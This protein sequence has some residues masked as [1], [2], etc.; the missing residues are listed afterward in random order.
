MK[1]NKFLI[2]FYLFGHINIAYNLD[3]DHGK[4]VLKLHF[5]S[6]ATFSSAIRLVT[7]LSDL[8]FR[9]LMRNEQVQCL[10]SCFTLMNVFIVYNAQSIQILINLAIYFRPRDKHLYKNHKKNDALH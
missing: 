6:S 10:Y 4:N 8:I 7:S 5:E 2:L 9:S 1:Q 3:N